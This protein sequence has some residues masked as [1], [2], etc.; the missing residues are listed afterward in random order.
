MCT[1][2]T[3]GIRLVAL[4]V[5][6]AVS[7]GCGRVSLEWK[8]EVRL[9]DGRLIIID[10]TAKGRIQRELG[11]PTGWEPSEETLRIQSPLSGAKAPPTWRSNLVPILLDYDAATSTW[12]VVT[13]Y[14]YCGTWYAMG[15][16]ASHYVV[17]ASTGGGDWRTVPLDP[18]RGGQA[19]NLLANVRH[20]GESALVR[21]AEKEER[22]RRD[23]EQFKAITT[24]FRTN[25]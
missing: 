8:E 13:T 6:L 4:C 17:Y 24:I 23:S 14:V 10:R 1:S 12:I 20:T 3:R 7:A 18:G 22:R 2:T 21:E 9:S 16:P 5:L 25:C 11:G 15:R 19:A